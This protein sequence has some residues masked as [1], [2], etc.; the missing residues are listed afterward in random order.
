MILRYL[1]LIAFGLALLII[2]A[3]LVAGIGG[4]AYYRGGAALISVGPIVTLVLGVVLGIPLAYLVVLLPAGIY[5]ELTQSPRW[6]P[7]Y[8]PEGL[9]PPA[10]IAAPR[11]AAAGR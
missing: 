4:A 10:A 2:A 3:S 9:I 6:P 8:S 11:R 5:R 7:R 1:A